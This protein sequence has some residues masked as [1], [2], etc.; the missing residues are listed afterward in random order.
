MGKLLSH[1]SSQSLFRHDDINIDHHSQDG[2]SSLNGDKRNIINSQADINYYHSAHDAEISGKVWKSSSSL[3][4]MRVVE[5]ANERRSPGGSSNATLSSISPSRSNSSFQERSTQ[6]FVHMGGKIGSIHPNDNFDNSRRSNFSDANIS[7]GKHQSELQGNWEM[8]NQSTHRLNQHSLQNGDY[9]MGKGNSELFRNNTHHSN[10]QTPPSNNT[11]SG[12]HNM[13]HLENKTSNHYG[14]N[15][16]NHYSTLHGY[17]P[18]LPNQPVPPQQTNMH[19]QQNIGNT[20]TSILRPQNQSK[21]NIGHTIPDQQPMAMD[22]FSLPPNFN[23]NQQILF[24]AVPMRN[25]NGQ[26]LQPVQMV[27]IGNGQSTFVVPSHPSLVD[28]SGINANPSFTGIE[29]NGIPPQPHYPSGYENG[30]NTNNHRAGGYTTH[31]IDRGTYSPNM[32]SNGSSNSNKK[33]EKR[34]GK[35]HSGNKQHVPMFANANTNPIP[36]QYSGVSSKRSMAVGN[37]FHAPKTVNDNDDADPQ[38]DLSNSPPASDTI[39]ALYH[40]T[41]RPPLSSLLGH[42]RRLS[43]DQVGCRLLQQSLDEDGPNA[44]TAILNEGL[45]FLTEAM[46][47]PFGNYLFQKILEKIT[48]DERLILVT[49]V[50]PRLVN[51]ALN[52]HGTRSVQKVVEMSALDNSAD[53]NSRSEKGSVAEIVTSALAPS[54]ARLCIDSHGNHVIQRILQKLPHNHSKFVFDAVAQSVGDVARHRH[55]CCVIQRCL[56]SPP[57][58]ARSNLVKRIVEKSLDL[59]Q[60]AYGNYVVQYVLDVCGDD[61][62]GAVCESVVGKIGLL[63]IQKFSSNVMEKCLERS[64]DRVRELHLQELSSPDKIRELM[65]DPFGNY[66]VQKA[67]SVANHSQAVRLV[68]AMRPH[69]PG[70]RNT[71]GGRRIVAKISRRFPRFDPSIGIGMENGNKI[72]L[73]HQSQAYRVHQ[74]VNYP[75]S[76]SM[77]YINTPDPGLA[78]MNGA[79]LP[80]GHDAD[81]HN[82]LANARRT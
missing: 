32:M 55:G 49:T 42:V 39:T 51:A 20:G 52:L 40:S 23:P 78:T 36:N 12:I 6:Q 76:I 54:A 41:H 37:D 79:S 35:A 27:N 34:K 2:I 46:T 53:T 19:Y 67:L 15:N 26:M 3:G 47:D 71:A 58:P 57:S 14:L 7:H 48:A 11:F 66:V 22:N 38:I 33:K 28:P 16:S 50:G 45:P 62:A 1:N 21:L 25:G 17:S 72:P 81:H 56:D 80:I 59:M 8:S 61:E 4:S 60:D 74:H 31:P 30:E 68:E 75:L 10:N 24:M 69:L 29:K 73:D 65:I 70:M 13:S 77:G 63:A 64:S 5:K 44:A 9:R 43:R 82:H 18:T